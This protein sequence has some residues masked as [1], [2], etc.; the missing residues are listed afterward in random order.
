[1]SPTKPTPSNGGVSGRRPTLDY[2]PVATQIS[3]LLGFA[4][5]D[6]RD[7]LDLRTESLAATVSIA[8]KMLVDL[9]LLVDEVPDERLRKDLL[10]Q[11]DRVAEFLLGHRHE[12]IGAASPDLWDPLKILVA[13]VRE[14]ERS[15]ST[16]V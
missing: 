6:V 12:L 14:D 11:L 9:Q 15:A 5:R 2:V 1:M 8:D 4:L 3:E 13:D 16:S 7:E 10:G